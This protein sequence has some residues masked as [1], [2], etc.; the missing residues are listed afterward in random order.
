ME[1]IKLSTM[2]L[3]CYF[4]S[5]PTLTFVVY[6]KAY[7]NANYCNTHTTA[8]DIVPKA[9]KNLIWMNYSYRNFTETHGRS[10]VCNKNKQRQHVKAMKDNN[11]S[12]DSDDAATVSMEIHI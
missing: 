1:H 5:T 3:L 6:W 10:H 12:H 8:I 7:F 2:S 9:K 4:V 11:A